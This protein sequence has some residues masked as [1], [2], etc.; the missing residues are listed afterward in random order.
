MS[1]TLI[2]F[3]QKCLK[4]KKIY[5]KNNLIFIILLTLF[6]IYIFLTHYPLTIKY[7]KV[8][9]ITKEFVKTELILLFILLLEINFIATYI[10]IKKI[11]HK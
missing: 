3:L 4:T 10:Y 1:I 6:N 8:N 11:L 5:S 7:S 9:I 2:L